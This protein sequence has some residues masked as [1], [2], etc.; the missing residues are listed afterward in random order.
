[1]VSA[2][3]PDVRPAHRAVALTFAAHGAVVGTFATP[4]PGLA[5]PPPTHTGGLG[6][7]LLFVAVGA[8]AAMPF[9]G[10]ITRH[11]D[12]RAATRLL[13]V[14]WCASLVLPAFAPNLP[15]FAASLFVY[16][17]TS[18]LA[19]VAMNAQGVAVE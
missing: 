9:A 15:L 19:D 4:L 5:R 11:L 18:G 14:L 10:L 12:L 6:I 7:A 17:A 3:G 2:P 13:M 1:R 16:G 8:M